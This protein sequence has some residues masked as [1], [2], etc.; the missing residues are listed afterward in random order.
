M[1]RARHFKTGELFPARIP[2]KAAAFS[3]D[4]TISFRPTPA[5]GWRPCRIGPDFE[6]CAALSAANP[7]C[8]VP[9]FAIALS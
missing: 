6:S 5:L 9:D 3:T 7:G 4:L 2:V 8:I 1:E